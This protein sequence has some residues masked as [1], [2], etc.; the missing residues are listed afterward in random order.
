LD[1]STLQDMKPG[2]NARVQAI[3]KHF[4][5][6]QRL[7]Q[8]GLSPGAE[9]QL[10]ARYPLRGPYLVMVGNNRI[11]IDYH[12]TSAVEVNTIPGQP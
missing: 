3:N 7:A 6:S 4:K 1:L 10:L 8:M 11:A 2:D 9:I 12:L 5:G